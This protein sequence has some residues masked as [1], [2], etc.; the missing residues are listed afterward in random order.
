M[1]L[2]KMIDIYNGIAFQAL[3]NAVNV[4]VL[5]IYIKFLS[6]LKDEKIQ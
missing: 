1:S 6:C 3:S 4:Y 5:L 2:Q